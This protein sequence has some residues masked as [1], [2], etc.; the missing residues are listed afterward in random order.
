MVKQKKPA[1][2]P[3]NHESPLAAAIHQLRQRPLRADERERFE[4]SVAIL[5][6]LADSQGASLQR[7]I[8]DGVGLQ[9][10][11]PFCITDAKKLKLYN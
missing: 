11:P 3:K 8:T 9:V 4:A 5:K 2:V 6:S 1:A 10:S 7:P